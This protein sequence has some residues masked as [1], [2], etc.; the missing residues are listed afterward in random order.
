[1]QTVQNSTLRI[2]GHDEVDLCARLNFFS[3]WSARAATLFLNAGTAGTT[4]RV[5]QMG[6]R[7]EFD[8][9]DTVYLDWGLCNDD[10]D[11]LAET[12]VFELQ[13]SRNKPDTDNVGR[14]TR[15]YQQSLLQHGLDVALIE[16]RSSQTLATVLGQLPE[17]LHQ[18]SDFGDGHQTQVERHAGAFAQWFADQVHDP[19]PAA[20]RPQDGLLSK[21][22][23]VYD[24]VA[25]ATSAF[26]LRAHLRNIETGHLSTLNNADLAGLVNALPTANMTPVQFF[27]SFV[28]AVQAVAVAGGPVNWNENAAT[29]GTWVQCAQDF[30]TV[31]AGVNAATQ[32]VNFQNVLQNHIAAW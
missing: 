9:T 29:T 16:S 3:E 23:Y 32:V 13:N 12:A 19:N 28:N 1:M 11:Y 7:C 26:A 30:V 17:I 5:T 31:L 10:I 4:I 15:R 27:V 6:G 2:Y 14:V 24:V 22:L 21:H 20:N 18:P 25:A 8:G